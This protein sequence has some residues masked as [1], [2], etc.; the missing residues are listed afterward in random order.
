MID[1][2]YGHWITIIHCEELISKLL[3]W[4]SKLMVSYIVA[5][6]NYRGCLKFQLKLQYYVLGQETHMESSLENCLRILH[7]KP[8]TG[9]K[10][11]HTIY[12]S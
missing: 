6:R 10:I 4:S 12:H 1:S 5:V 8:K 2:I 9:N 7:V 11:I 3:L